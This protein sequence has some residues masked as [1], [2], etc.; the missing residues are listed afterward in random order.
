[1][2]FDIAEIDIS[3]ESVSSQIKT[4]QVCSAVRERTSFATGPKQI[5]AGSGAPSNA[6]HRVNG[7]TRVTGVEYPSDT[8]KIRAEAL[9]QD[10]A[11]SVARDRNS[12]QDRERERSAEAP[13][14]RVQTAI[15]PRSGR[16]SITTISNGQIEPWRANRENSQKESASVSRASPRAGTRWRGFEDV[17]HRHRLPGRVGNAIAEP[18]REDVEV[19]ADGIVVE[20]EVLGQ[21]LGLRG[22]SSS[23]R[24]MRTRSR[25]V[26]D[27]SV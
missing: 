10:A 23:A 12:Q 2:R 5:E 20:V 7:K 3:S 18:H 8:S 14:S 6:D 11:D 16:K 19:V 1:V 22:R 24:R 9:D 25:L 13:L 15:R 26:R 27:D 21:L 4:E 17:K